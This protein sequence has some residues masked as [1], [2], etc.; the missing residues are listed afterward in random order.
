[1]PTTPLNVSVHKLQKNDTDRFVDVIRLFED[2]F[3]MKNLSVPDTKYLQRLLGKDNFLVFV[4]VLDNEVIGGLTAYVIEQYYSEKP[5][6]YIYDLAVSTSHQRQGVGKKLIAEFN[7]YCTEQGFEEV[8][9]QADKV[10]DYAL[11]FY[12]TT[13]PTAEEQVVHFY[14]TLNQANPPFP[15]KP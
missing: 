7:Q 5:L 2:V 9:V 14:Y 11:D 10:D 12:R 13:H 6:C 3:E 4:A 8:F 15:E 1:M